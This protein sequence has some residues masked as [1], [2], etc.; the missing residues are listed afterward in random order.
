MKLLIQ[1]RY[2]V[3]FIDNYETCK[4]VTENYY[5]HFHLDL[6]FAILYDRNC[7]VRQ[8]GTRF[9]IQCA[10]NYS[11]NLVIINQVTPVTIQNKNHLEI[12]QIRTQIK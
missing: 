8:D 2:H 4:I 9:N 10:F 3:L 1:N 5:F 12:I 7:C 6:T 11:D